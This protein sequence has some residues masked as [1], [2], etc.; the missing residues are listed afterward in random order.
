MDAYS[1]IR[2]LRK[3][4]RQIEH[5]ELIERDLTDEEVA[6]CIKKN[7]IREELLSLLHDNTNPSISV[8]EDD[9]DISSS[10]AASYSNTSQSQSDFAQPPVSEVDVNV[11]VDDEEADEN[12]WVKVIKDLNPGNVN[13][14]SR[15]DN[16]GNGE[17][18]DEKN[19]VGSDGGK[20]AT[21]ADAGSTM[22]KRAVTK[23]KDVFKKP[24]SPDVSPTKK[25][26]TEKGKTK[27]GLVEKW[28]SSSFNVQVLEGH[29]DLILTVDCADNILVSGSR[30]TTVRVW[31]L[32][33]SARE[34]RCLGGHTGS[35]T[36]VL[37]LPAKQCPQISSHFGVSEN[38]HIVFSVST[39]CNLKLWIAETGEL[40]T[41]IYTYNPITKVAYY[42]QNA[43]LIIA[44]AGGKLELWDVQ[45]KENITS[46]HAHSDTITGL[47]VTG[48]HI[49]TSSGVDSEI[50]GFEV[51]DRSL[52]CVYVSENTR[53]ISGHT[54]TMRQVRAL[55][56]KG[57]NL[58]Y[59]DDGVN[60]KI[61]NWRKGLVKKL[62]N[63]REEFGITDTLC[64][65][66]DVMVTSAYDLDTGHGYLNVFDITS[67]PVY[68]ATID[69][70]DTGRILDLCCQE[71]SPG[72]ITMATA[73]MELQV[74]NQV[75]SKSKDATVSAVFSPQ[76]ARFAE[77]SD[78][79]S[80]AEFTDTDSESPEGSRASS[81]RGSVQGQ[82]Y[83]SWCSL[84]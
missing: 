73:G 23:E 26:K 19:S 64:C 45:D 71:T 74:W 22:T 43:W 27:S 42:G 77:N 52:H 24:S 29:N 53:D 62:A 6:K 49:F 78:I 4:L 72:V 34:L 79:E 51:R 66:G 69:D 2:K 67:D 38:L 14:S 56:V 18:A 30:D 25:L 11:S 65:H 28:R 84:V 1:K 61:L 33:P 7:S 39:D 75:P 60:V 35:I 10:T 13:N 8:G 12:E 31:K 47:C 54:V 59:G 16:N 48:N 21:D 80:E 50:K 68:M 17:A 37:I 5:L 76:L 44:S 70:S 63:H 57:D 15:N 20:V 82:G 58:V 83:M 81:R 9:N 40:L 41:T 36:D 46:E 55:A 3:K 32:E